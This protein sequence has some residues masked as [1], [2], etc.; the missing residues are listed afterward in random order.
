M[1]KAAMKDTAGESFSIEVRIADSR[2]ADELAAMN[3]EFNGVEVSDQHV[4]S[5]LANGRELV[6]IAVVNGSAAGFACGQVWSSFCYDWLF[7]EITEMYVRPAYRNRGVGAALL[8]FLEKRLKEQGVMSIKIL[9][10]QANERALK[11]YTSLGYEHKDDTAVLT[12]E[13][14][15]NGAQK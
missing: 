9:T 3:Y 1:A 13:L 2:D 8:T 15:S 11:L 14:D 7:G 10:S 6:A 12:K 5:E 4:I